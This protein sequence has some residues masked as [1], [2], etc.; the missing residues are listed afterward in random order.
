MKSLGFYLKRFWINRQ[1]DFFLTFKQSDKALS[2]AREWTELDADNSEAWLYLASLERAKNKPRDAITHYTRAAELSDQSAAAWFNA[3]FTHEELEEYESAQVCFEKAIAADA[4]FD[5]AWY[6]LGQ[7]HARYGRFEEAA[8]AFK[9][10]SE[11][12][13]FSPYGWHQWAMTER[14]RGNSE[15]ALQIARK[16]ERYEPRHAEALRKELSGMAEKPS[17]ASG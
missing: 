6:G 4:N 10:T 9:R 16:L 7:C 12:Q 1:L 5:R 14:K 2:L 3:G 8:A 15:L 17:G 11:L 13:P